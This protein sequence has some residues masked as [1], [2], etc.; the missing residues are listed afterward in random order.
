MKHRLPLVE[1]VAGKKRKK[2]KVC[3]YD[4]HYY[5]C[6][7]EEYQRRTGVSERVNG[8]RLDKLPRGKSYIGHGPKPQPRVRGPRRE[9]GRPNTQGTE[10]SSDP[11]SDFP[12]L[13]RVRKAVG[14]R[15]G[16]TCRRQGKAQ[17]EGCDSGWIP[18]VPNTRRCQRLAML[19]A[20][21][22]R[23]SGKDG[24]RAGDPNSRRDDIQRRGEPDEAQGPA[25]SEGAG[26]GSADSWKK[27]CG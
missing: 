1:D 22:G 12:L 15:H 20:V 9:T 5:C 13:F 11:H 4:H 23:P 10:L 6:C 14:R 24:R 7:S 21:D 26:S 27:T 2:T 3:C 18:V 17:H 8:R 19:A 25:T 16:M